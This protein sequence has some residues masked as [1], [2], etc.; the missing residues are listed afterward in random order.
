MEQ[1][2]RLPVVRRGKITDRANVVGLLR[3]FHTASAMPFPFSAPWA[4]GLFQAHCEQPD[5]A[6]F[7]LDVDG[8]AVGVLL[9]TSGNSPLGPFRIA[10]ELA[11][12]VAPEHR[13]MSG[14]MLDAYEAWAAE[15]RCAFVGVASLAAF[16]RASLIYERRGYS[17]AETHFIKALQP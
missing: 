6:A 17:Q 15:R 8:A 13:G 16:L 1:L 14:G 7:I 11:W 4:A 10:Q 2:P 3:N 9:A 5:K 12:W